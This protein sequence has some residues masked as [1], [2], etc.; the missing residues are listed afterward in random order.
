MRTRRKYW[1]RS[2]LQG[3]TNH[4]QYHTLFVELRL[5]DREY[6]FSHN[7]RRNYN[8]TLLC[9][10]NFKSKKTLGDRAFSSAAPALWNSL[11]LA[12]NNVDQP[13]E[14]FKKKIKGH[15]FTR[16]FAD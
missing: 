9:T 15:L 4:D 3:R 10:P 11:P 2:M 5:H 1:V 16:V 7:L 6:F 8:G 12:I 14:S 13:I